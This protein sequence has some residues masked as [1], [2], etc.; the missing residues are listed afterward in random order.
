MTDFVLMFFKDYQEWAI[1]VSVLLNILIAVLGV[2]PSVFLTAA[3]LLFFGFWYGTAVSFIGE[4]AG[5]AVS[6]WLYR[7]GFQRVSRQKLLRYPRVVSLLDAK[8]KEAFILIFSLRLLPFVPSGLVTF[9]GA[10]GSVS[11]GI[12]ITSSSLGKLPALL[13]ES[14]SVYSITQWNTEGKILLAAVAIGGIYM[15]IKKMKR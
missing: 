12:F 6:F 9:A 15:I 13:M 7:K 14:Y 3:N 8:G 2:V 11:A 1:A 4:A 5:A 10:V